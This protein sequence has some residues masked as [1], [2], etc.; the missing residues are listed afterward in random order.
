MLTAALFGALLLQQPT[1]AQTS[2]D[3]KQQKA[4]QQH[5]KD[6]QSDV[7]MGKKFVI[8]VEKEEK[9][10]ENK[11]Y[12][13]RVNRIG[14]E[15]AA[16]AQ[17]EKVEVN[18]GDKR[19][20]KF[21]YTFKVIKGD[22]VN[23]FSIPGGFIYVYEGLIKYA[24]SDDEIAAV[25]AHEISHAE[26]RHIATLMHNTSKAS[27]PAF[28]AVLAAIASGNPQAIGPVIMV[29]SNVLQSLTSGWSVDA[30]KSADHGGFQYMLK[31]KYNPTAMLTFMER[32]AQDEHNDAAR[33]QDWGIYQTHPPGRERA[34]AITKDMQRWNIPIQRSA[35]TTRFRAEVKPGKEGVDIWF[36]KRKLY[37]FAGTDALKR[38]DDAASR[39]DRAFDQGPSLYEVASNGNDVTVRRSVL[40]TVQPEDAA[41]ANTTR[42]ELVDKAIQS[43]RATLYNYAFNVWQD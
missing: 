32:L 3:V 37:T 15:L 6:I 10:S 29:A 18:W 1:F 16:I 43:V 12:I 8:E 35:V 20:N 41:A 42:R 2:V 23:A 19:L 24:E 9:L 21:D 34:N 7:D 39:I 5:Q 31:S 17:Q 30:E 13:D 11:E 36:N 4:E 27:V 40:F 22:E 33:N 28:I 38:A 14:Q 26:Q 25:L